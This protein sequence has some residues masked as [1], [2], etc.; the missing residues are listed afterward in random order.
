MTNAPPR[1]AT[2]SSSTPHPSGRAEQQAGAF[3]A[4]EAA[5][6]GLDEVIEVPRMFGLPD[7][8]LRDAIDSIESYETSSKPVPATSPASTSSTPTSR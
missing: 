6:A 1:S 8:V 2:R 4:F 5:V 7:Y 3:E